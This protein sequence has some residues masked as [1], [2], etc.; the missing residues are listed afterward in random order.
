MLKEGHIEKINYVKDDVFLKSTVITVEKD[1]SVKMAVDA[2]ALSQAI[3]KDKNQMP[4]LDNLLDLAAE[5]VVSEKVEARY[6]SV[7]MTYAY[8]QTPL[9]LL[10]AKQCN[11]QIFLRRIHWK[12]P[13][14]NRFLWSDG[15]ADTN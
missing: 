13:Y 15:Y 7:D 14:R 4:N 3:I 8:G 6:S 10:T 12:K 11:F 2:R 5:K 9:H 1:R